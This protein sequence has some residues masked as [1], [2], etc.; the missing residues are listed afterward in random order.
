ML[1][2][3]RDHRMFECFP[4]LDDDYIEKMAHFYTSE[5]ARIIFPNLHEIPFEKWLYRQYFL[6]FE[7]PITTGQYQVF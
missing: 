2:S 7:K 6:N 1:E 3:V 5:T 4:L